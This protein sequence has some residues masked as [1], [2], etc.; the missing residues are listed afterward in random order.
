MADLDSLIESLHP[1]NS[2]RNA[3]K[4]ATNQVA[5]YMKEKTTLSI[6]E[7]FSGGSFAKKTMLRG[8]G[9]VDLVFFVNWHDISTWTSSDFRTELRQ[10]YTGISRLQGAASPRRNFRAIRVKQK[11]QNYGRIEVDMLLGSKSI[12][13]T[14]IVSKN[15]ISYLRPSLS[16]YQVEWWKTQGGTNH[17]ILCNLVKLA[18]YWVVKDHRKRKLCPSYALELMMVKSCLHHLNDENYKELFH[19]FVKWIVETELRTRVVFTDNYSPELAYSYRNN[20]FNLIDPADPTNYIAS[21]HNGLGNKRV[22]R[23][24]EY[25]EKA[26]DNIENN[27]WNFLGI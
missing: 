8:R 18:K 6:A 25:A 21:K 15:A 13:P 7:T 24:V 20:D 23:F 2:E 17:Q 9:E 10:V 5:T 14:S 4:D 26:L 22:H 16:P 11:I 1:D 12:T 19:R 3:I 27:Q